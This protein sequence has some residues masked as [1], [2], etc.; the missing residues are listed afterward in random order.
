MKVHAHAMRDRTTENLCCYH[1]TAP[2]EKIADYGGLEVGLCGGHA[3][4]V[5][6]LMLETCSTRRCRAL[7]EEAIACQDCG[8]TYR[9]CTAHGGRKAAARSLKSHRGVYHPQ[10]QR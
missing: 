5:P 7:V 6:V 1:C 3:E 4:A 8:K 10:V 2:A 9:K